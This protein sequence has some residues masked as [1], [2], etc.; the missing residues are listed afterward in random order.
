MTTKKILIIIFVTA[1]VLRIALNVARQELFFQKP[2][3]STGGQFDDR[4]SSDS[5]W[6]NS[7]AT[8][9]LTGRG[10]ASIPLHIVDWESKI[11]AKYMELKVVDGEYVVH[12]VIPPLYT[13]FL[14]FCYF[15][16]G[17]NTLAYF[18]PQIILSSLTCVL[19]YLIASEIFNKIAALFAGFLVVFNL[20]LIFWSSFV[21]TETLFI[22]LL[23]LFFL[24]LIKGSVKNNFLF[25]YL[26]AVIFGLACLTRITLIPF[27]PILFVWQV[28]FSSKNRKENIKVAFLTALIIFAV[29]LPWGLRNYIVLGEFNV[30]TEESGILVG[31][32]SNGE[33]Y[34]DIVIN[35][36]YNSHKSLIS[37]TLFFIKDNF[38][39]YLISCW[40]RFVL[41][42][43][44]FTYAM[45]PLAKV[46]KGLS[47][48]ILFPAAFWGLIISRN[49]GG[50]GTGLVIVF[51]FYHAL[52][53]TASFVDLGLVYRYPIQPFLCIFAGYAFYELYKKLRNF[54]SKA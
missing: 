7:A 24:L 42:W 22:F 51:I 32:V 30:F 18:I 26:G 29:L 45:R 44:P 40:H 4:I 37:K 12:K 52:L 38:K 20:D 6:Y 49:K 10:I 50:K 43:S 8:G 11:S 48:L 17:F 13:L 31:S 15:T 1:M 36:E 25:I 41:F 14:A 33:Q 3:L 53:H 39:V 54:G 23:C 2:F 35:K 28:Y 19:I 16:G 5:Q 9:F 34:K 46:Y 21:R 47:W 27:L